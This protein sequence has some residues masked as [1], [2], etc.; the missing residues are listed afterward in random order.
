MRLDAGFVFLAL[1]FLAAELAEEHTAFDL[2]S[3]FRNA[4]YCPWYL[5]ERDSTDLLSVGLALW[6]AFQRWG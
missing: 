6:A 1:E 5:N 2:A 3:I 4:P